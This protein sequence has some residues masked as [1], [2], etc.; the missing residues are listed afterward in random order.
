MNTVIT[1][2]EPNLVCALTS[3][4]TIGLTHFLTTH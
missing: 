3:G 1:N 2:I 4:G